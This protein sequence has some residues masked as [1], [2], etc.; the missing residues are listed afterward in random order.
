MLDV[1][2]VDEWVGV[3]NEGKDDCI[4][5]FHY[6]AVQNKAKT[7][8]KGRPVFDQIPFVKI[9]IPGDNTSVV[10]RKVTDADK[11]RWPATWERFCKKQEQVAE[12]T[13]V[14]HWPR[15]TV[16]QVALLKHLGIPTV[17]ALANVGD[18]ALEKIGPGARELQNHARAWL[19]PQSD[20]EGELQ[21]ELASVKSELKAT[22]ARLDEATRQLAEA[23]EGDEDEPKAKRGRRK[24][25]AA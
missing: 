10:D 20:R 13:P 5:H 23:F 9:R 1:G 6:E 19:K 3:A 22:Q 21:A 2:T 8:Q 12:G 18:S 25:E 4:A 16:A 11:E 15:L 24:K 7:E 14:E 17:E